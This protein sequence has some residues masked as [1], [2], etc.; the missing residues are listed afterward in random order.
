MKNFYIMMQKDNLKKKKCVNMKRK[1][2]II[3]L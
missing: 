2:T 1:L 3:D